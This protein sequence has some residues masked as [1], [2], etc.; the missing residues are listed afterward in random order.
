MHLVMLGVAGANGSHAVTSTLKP[1]GGVATLHRFVP[2]ET[3]IAIT[4]T[5]VTPSL[6]SWLRANRSMAAAML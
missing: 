4:S 6:H 1:L 3:V 2:N 5:L